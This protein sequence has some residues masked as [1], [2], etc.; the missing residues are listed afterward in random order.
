MI[1]IMTL[2]VIGLHKLKM[3]NKELVT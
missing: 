1:I 2:M 3:R